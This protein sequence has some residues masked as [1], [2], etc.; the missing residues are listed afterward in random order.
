VTRARTILVAVLLAALGVAAPQAQARSM[1]SQAAHLAGAV[2]RAHSAKARKRAV[3]AVLKA[4]HVAVITPK[5]RVLQRGSRSAARIQ[6]YNFEV[7]ALAAQLGRGEMRSLG[8]LTSILGAAGFHPSK[9]AFPPSVMAQVLQGA[10]KSVVRHPKGGS[11]GGLIVRDL[12]LDR[13]QGRVDLARNVSENTQFDALQSTLLMLDFANAAKTR[14]HAGAAAG[15]GPRAGSATLCSKADLARKAVSKALAAKEGDTAGEAI[16]ET[17]GKKVEDELDEFEVGEFTVGELKTIA[18][19]IIDGVHGSLL[20][21]SVRVDGPQSLPSVHYNH[22]SAEHNVVHLTMRVRMVDKWGDELIDCGDLAGDKLPKQ[23]GIPGIPVRWELNGLYKHSALSYD[24][25]GTPNPT[26]GQT[27][28]N[29]E[30]SFDVPLRTELVPG[31]GLEKDDTGITDAVPLVGQQTA[32]LKSLANLATYLFP[33]DGVNRA[34]MRWHVTYHD[35]PPLE[36]RYTH[37]SQFNGDYTSND[38]PHWSTHLVTDRTFGLSSSIP[39]TLT[40]PA[41]APGQTALPPT[42]VSGTGPLEWSTSNGSWDFTATLS[43][44]NSST[45]NPY[46]CTTHTT[47]DLTRPYDGNARVVRGT[48]T[49]PATTG[50]APGISGFQFGIQGVHEIWHTH[51]TATPTGDAPPGCDPEPDTDDDQLTYADT[52]ETFWQPSIAGGGEEDPII[53]LDDTGWVPGSGNIIATRVARDPNIQNMVAGSYGE[54]DGSYTDTFELVA[55][56]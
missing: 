37:T 9:G 19:H 27:D 10:I 8:D 28:K 20:A 54:G 29:G 47:A 11:L 33:K 18:S 13:K 44:T 41:G 30:A 35:T 16:R 50:A 25:T 36:L 3:T 14:G 52:F 21:Y 32:G 5:G 39:L 24:P 23:G 40:P 2:T 51:Q 31:R 55:S 49:P 15:P 43:G 22:S 56:P 17:Y 26:Q 7:G 38:D 12:G 6:L 1:K 53:N 45:N 34:P 42:P 48:L 46:S 4:L